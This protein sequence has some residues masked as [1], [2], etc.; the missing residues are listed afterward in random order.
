MFLRMT[1]VCSSYIDLLVGEFHF[2]L[3]QLEELHL[4]KLDLIFEFLGSGQ[5]AST[6][7][8]RMMKNYRLSA[9]FMFNA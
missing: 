8:A 3:S 6:A 5:S 4:Y 2:R 9:S 7:V 1:K